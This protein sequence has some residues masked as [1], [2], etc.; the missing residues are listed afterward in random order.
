MSRAHVR[1]TYDGPALQMHTMD[2][3]LLAPALLAFGDLCEETGRV[4]Y[5]DTIRV[6]V[7]VRASFRTGSFGIDLSVVPQLAQ[8]LIGWFSS[9]GATA[10]ANGKTILEVIGIGGAGLIGLLRWLRG[11]RIRRVE[12]VPQGRRIAVDDGDAIEVEERVLA[13]LQRRS[14]REALQ[15]VVEPIER[16]GVERLAIGTDT[17]IKVLIERPEAAWFHAPAPEDALLMEE[18]RTIAFS[19]VGLSFREDNKWRL[20]DGQ[21]TV[22]VTIADQDFLQRVDRNLERFA[23]GDILLAQTR[24]AQW[25]TPQGLRTD[26]TIVRV[27]EHRLGA[28]QIPLPIE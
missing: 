16:D 8:Q 15:R 4:L 24:I 6:H 7:E 14:V 5:G 1:L 2:V 12:T 21:N 9:E 20:Y 13:L 25:Q 26:Y 27:L 28:E 22:Y 3:R 11:R 10:I 23:K 18:E 19:I 17:D